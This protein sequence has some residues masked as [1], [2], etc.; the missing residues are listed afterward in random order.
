VIET[1][2]QIEALKSD[3]AVAGVALSNAITSNNLVI[4]TICGMP[5]D[6]FDILTQFLSPIV[7]QDTGEVGWEELT[8]AS[9]AHLLRTCL[10]RKDKA[11][12]PN[13]NQTAIDTIESTD[14]LKR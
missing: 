5:E 11:T 14:K 12:N 8:V 2:S 10:S 9:T 1:A 13:T 3:Q 4:R 7:E 6:Q